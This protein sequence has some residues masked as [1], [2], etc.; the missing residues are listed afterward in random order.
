M[1]NL[2]TIS[3]ILPVIF[4]LLSCLPVSTFSKSKKGYCCKDGKVT[5]GYQS[6][7]PK[8]FY[9]SKLLAEKY[10][11]SVKKNK[12]SSSQTSLL[13]TKVTAYCCEQGKMKKKTMSLKSLKSSKNCSKDKT[14][15]AE[16]CGF[17]C[18]DAKVFSVSSNDKKKKCEKEGKLYSSERLAESNCGWCCQNGKVSSVTKL[19][20]CKNRKLYT[21]KRD[22]DKAC[23]KHDK[24]PS[25]KKKKDLPR[26]P[27]RTILGKRPPVRMPDLY[28]TRIWT[29]PST[30]RLWV[31]WKNQGS[32]AAEK[33]FTERISLKGRFRHG[34]TELTSYKFD[35]RN[36]F[37]IRVNHRLNHEVT[38]DYPIY[39]LGKTTVRFTIDGTDVHNESDENN[40]TM[41]KEV[42]CRSLRVIGPSFSNNKL[43]GVLKMKQPQPDDGRKKE[44][45]AEDPLKIKR[46]V[47]SGHSLEIILDDMY[48]SNPGYSCYEF[49]F[50]KY[51]I[52]RAMKPGRIHF[53]TVP[54]GAGPRV[55][56]PVSKNYSP[57]SNEGGVDLRSKDILA[58][59]PCGIEYGKE[60]DYYLA[61]Y[62]SADSKTEI[63]RSEV[64][65]VAWNPFT[66]RGPNKPDLTGA[67]SVT[68]D[69]YMKIT[70]RNQGGENRRVGG[71]Y[72]N[73]KVTYASPLSARG[74][75]YIYEIDPE[76][77]LDDSGGEVSFT[78]E[79]Q[80]ITPAQ[81]AEMRIDP[82]MVLSDEDRDN[83]SLNTELTCSAYL[84]P[85]GRAFRPQPGASGGLKKLNKPVHKMNKPAFMGYCCQ[86]GRVEESEEAECGSGL[87]M[88]VSSRELAE[89]RCNDLK[90]AWQSPKKDGVYSDSIPV[91][92]LVV[93]GSGRLARLHLHRNDGYA[94]KTW[95]W[96]Q[97]SAPAP[98]SSGRIS[99]SLPVPE[100]YSGATYWLRA[101]FYVGGVIESV[102]DG[103]SSPWFEIDAGSSVLLFPKYTNDID[104]MLADRPRSNIVEIGWRRPNSGST[105]RAGDEIYVEIFIKEPATE[106]I[107]LANLQL[108]K[109]N[110]PTG[111]T[112][113]WS[114][115]E[116]ST[117]YGSGKTVHHW[118]SA[119]IKLPI[120]AG[121]SN[122][123]LEPKFYVGSRVVAPT[124]QTGGPPKFNID[125]PELRS[126]L[127]GGDNPRLNN[128]S[129]RDESEGQLKKREPRRD[130]DRMLIDRNI[131]AKEIVP[132][133]PASLTSASGQ[134]ASISITL[135]PE[136]Q[137]NIYSTTDDITVLFE[138]RSVTEA[139]IS[140]SF[141]GEPARRGSGPITV[142]NG[143]GSKQYTYKAGKLAAGKY[144]WT[145][146]AN[147]TDRASA[148]KTVP[149]RIDEALVMAM[150]PDLVDAIL[151]VELP[152]SEEDE[153]ES[154]SCEPDDRVYE[155][156]RLINAERASQGVG[157]LTLHEGN[158][159]VAC[160]W[161]R[162]MCD[163]G[164][165]EHRAPDGTRDSTGTSGA[166]SGSLECGTS[167][168]ANVVRGQLSSDGHRLNMLAASHNRIGI[169]NGGC[170]NWTL[171]YSN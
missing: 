24:K 125:S 112:W 91:N 79:L 18:S 83:N 1:K 33:T 127:H 14:K 141:N 26:S 51:R 31:E 102:F 111:K 126:A 121:G 158:S 107:G 25:L 137:G 22:A 50:A 84:P 53:Y 41:K 148:Q 143:F 37:P 12:S 155:L 27:K 88:T 103:G 118:V 28:P 49:V 133:P 156:L 57:P 95:S 6:Q 36:R 13:N 85:V 94:G 4:A 58:N 139:S 76:H 40:N 77:K 113:S 74:S 132:L 130:A 11:K 70:L 68:R 89:H 44:A 80:I 109:D 23:S 81:A 54:V 67:I 168:P 170:R 129:G 38:D 72:H 160:R 45:P 150:N 96:T 78:T 47:V 5:F 151:N 106:G 147:G 162:R 16:F 116:A 152:G 114:Q 171:F 97:L 108:Y 165:C 15:I 124:G 87:W 42:N 32:A 117:T 163:E 92:L 153:E 123:S 59:I 62:H 46:G 120:G 86:D 142:N 101:E 166:V 128:K 21:A 29:A 17:C 73:A 145:V 3:I 19:D 134:P 115:S 157:Q 144:S 93:Q 99:L 164:F 20:Q 161:S 110:H 149:L 75:K 82:G 55:P 122:Y 138:V 35:S 135:Q 65:T 61:A 167:N 34:D 7:C 10:C 71:G 43:G 64:F 90:L 9:P 159:E 169:G 154:E 52:V 104:R 100:G 30:C 105:F 48:D 69:C 98:D 56:R 119:F 66:T 63:G 2:K 8:S 146:T 131:I 39:I 140:M 60:F 136:K